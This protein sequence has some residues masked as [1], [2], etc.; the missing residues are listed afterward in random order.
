MEIIVVKIILVNL[1]ECVEVGG[2]G[3]Y[4]FFGIFI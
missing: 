4:R 1:C 2:D 3:K